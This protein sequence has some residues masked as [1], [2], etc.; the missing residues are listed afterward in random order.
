MEI[1][2]D[3]VIANVYNLDTV[4]KKLKEFLNLKPFLTKTIPLG[5]GIDARMALISL[6]NADLEFIECAKHP[7]PAQMSKITQVHLQSP[8]VTENTCLELEEGLSRMG[9]TWCDDNASYHC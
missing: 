2:L 3:S 1:K 5:S 6:S 9:F 7:H 8:A 4:L